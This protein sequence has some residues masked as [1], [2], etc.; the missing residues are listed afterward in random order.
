MP[1]CCCFELRKLPTCHH[2]HQA[3]PIADPETAAT[4]E[5]HSYD[6]GLP[7]AVPTKWLSTLPCYMMLQGSTFGIPGVEQHAH[8]LRD[9]SHSER[10]RND[11][12]HNVALAGVP[13][14]QVDEFTRLLHIVIVGGGPT[15][16]EVAGELSNLINRDLRH[17]YP[18]RARAMR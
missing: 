7:A 11:L 13:G 12:I 2:A 15:G 1:C 4:A 9:I 6:V 18:D 5:C 17:V 10:I 16:V 14:R 3:A 8:F